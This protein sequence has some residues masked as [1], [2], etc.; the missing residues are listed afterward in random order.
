LS[1]FV[2]SDNSALPISLKQQLTLGWQFVDQIFQLL[3][4]E[5]LYQRPIQLRHPFVFYLGHLP[6]FMHNQVCNYILKENESFSPYFDEIFERGIDPIVENPSQCHK[7]STV[8]TQWPEINAVKEYKTKAREIVLSNVAKLLTKNEMMAQKGR[9]LSMVVEHDLMHAETL[10]Y[11]LQVMDPK[12]KN[13]PSDKVLNYII[14]GDIHPSTDKMASIPGGQIKLGQD[15][16]A[17]SWG[18]DNEFPKHSTTVPSF[19]VDLLP[20]TNRQFLEFVEDGH[21]DNSTYWDPQDW[22]W[23]TSIGLQHP[24]VWFK[25]ST[26]KWYFSTLFERIPLENVLN[27]PALVSHAEASAYANWKGKRLPTEPELIRAAYGQAE[28]KGEKR[29]KLESAK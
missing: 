25:D 7:H 27:W 12:L 15:F 26:G 5:S 16:Y 10:L 19:S 2:P 28:A 14:N 8:P 4:E 23:K 13:R 6:S 29:R 24:N 20:V 11:M 3:K 1:I 9:V 21:Y 18:W 22:E 17:A